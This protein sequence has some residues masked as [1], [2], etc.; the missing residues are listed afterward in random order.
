MTLADFK[1]GN[2]WQGADVVRLYTN[3]EH[4]SLQTAL[5]WV[6]DVA[7]SKRASSA[8]AL[9][10]EE[11]GFEPIWFTTIEAAR[12]AASYVWN[13]TLGSAQG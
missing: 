11:K 6:L 2:G 9:V 10:F 1:D 7:W 12:A 4:H 8:V 5:D 3:I 13:A